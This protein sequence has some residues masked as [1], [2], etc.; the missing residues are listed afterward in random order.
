MI[1]RDSWFAGF[2]DDL[3]AVSWVGRDDNDRTRLTGATGALQVWN[4]FMGAGTSA[5][6]VG[7]AAGRNRNGMG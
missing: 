4:A 1:W 5:K 7:G 2:S 6:S 3:V